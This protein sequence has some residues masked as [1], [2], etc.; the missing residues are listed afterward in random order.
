MLRRPDVLPARHNA[1]LCRLANVTTQIWIRM[2]CLS[3]RKYIVFSSFS[4]TDAR[5]QSTYDRA[6]RSALIHLAHSAKMYAS[7]DTVHA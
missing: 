5:A 7:E 2:I 1:K 3:L 4:A 6:L